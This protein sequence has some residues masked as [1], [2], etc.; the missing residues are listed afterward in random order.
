LDGLRKAYILRVFENRDM[1]RIFGPQKEVKWLE[2][3]A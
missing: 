3:T 2:K 1:R